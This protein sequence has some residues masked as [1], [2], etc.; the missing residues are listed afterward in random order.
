MKLQDLERQSGV[1]AHFLAHTGANV[2]IAALTFNPR[3]MYNMEP[4][5]VHVASSPGPS[6][7]Y[8]DL[9]TR[10]GFGDKARTTYSVLYMY[11]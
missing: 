11:M 9:K 6:Q 4:V 8:Q 1:I 3:Y 2:H 5:N 7:A 10:S